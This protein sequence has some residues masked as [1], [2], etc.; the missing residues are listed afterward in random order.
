MSPLLLG[1]ESIDFSP[2]GDDLMRPCTL[3]RRFFI[4]V[5]LVLCIAVDA[6]AVQVVLNLQSQSFLS[7]D[8][9]FLGTDDNPVNPFYPQDDPAFPTPNTDG[10][11][12]DGDPNNPSN[13]TPL[14]GTITVDVDNILAPTTIQIVSANMDAT[15]TG[16]WL[17]E[18][19]PDDGVPTTGDDPRPALPA[20]IGIKIV[21]DV[22]I[23]GC[24]DIAYAAVRD[25]QY[26]Y[27]SA[28]YNY[29]T[30]TLTPVV[31]PVN[32]QG[33]F[34][35]TSQF[36]IY[37]SGIFEYWTDPFLLN[38]RERDSL[39]GD[40]APNQHDVDAST[41]P[42][43]ATPIANAPKSTYIVSGNLVTLTIPID[44]NVDNPGDLSQYVDGQ[45]LATFQ[46][47]AASDGDHNNDN[48]V[49]AA[50]YP[51]WRKIPSMFGGDPA[52]YD[53]WRQQFGEAGAGGSGAVPEPAA[54]GLIVIGLAALS[55][56]R[57]RTGR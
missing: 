18:N 14:T 37:T 43:T 39:V 19:Q 57:G 44:I 52:G 3:I 36:L 16:S 1:I 46:I 51:A 30:E 23:P 31:E 20:D 32:A 7:L 22:G 54:A 8:G 25:A 50:D 2:S 6:A 34:N 47:P 24:C 49:N 38:E 21:G 53:A 27:V 28:T 11:I 33:E 48:F 4:V 45:L 17:P 26:N 5:S 42:E 10:T 56:R 41:D 55:F 15:V 35:S 13:R 9:D 29:E 12:I 40:G